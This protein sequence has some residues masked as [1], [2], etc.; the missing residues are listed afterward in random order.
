MAIENINDLDTAEIK[1]DEN[2]ELEDLYVAIFKDNTMNFTSFENFPVYTKYKIDSKIREFEK[3]MTLKMQEQ[4][5][6]NKIYDNINYMG[7]E[8]KARQLLIDDKLATTEEVALMTLEE[9]TNKLLEKYQVVA[10]ET[11]DIILLDK[12]FAKEYAKHIKHLER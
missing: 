10:V 3:A 12:E 2:G 7:Q 6:V 4:R 1:Y 11:E 9:V 5:M 8:R